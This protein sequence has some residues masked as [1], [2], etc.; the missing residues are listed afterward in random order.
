M[1][2][3]HATGY[4]I[5]HIWCLFQARIEWEGCGRKG[6]WRKNGGMMEVGRWLVRME[7]RPTGL[8]VCLPLLSS[9]AR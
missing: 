8:S 7:W 5:Q 1:H 6:I 4:A 9:L 2:I 3:N